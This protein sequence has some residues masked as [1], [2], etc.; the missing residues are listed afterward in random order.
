[1][2]MNQ[3]PGLSGTV[4]GHLYKFFLLSTSDH[5]HNTLGNIKSLLSTDEWETLFKLF[6]QF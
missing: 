4:T 3:E 5:I 6:T 1:M 2:G